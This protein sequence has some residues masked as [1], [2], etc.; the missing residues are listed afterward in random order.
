[1]EKLQ[2]MLLLSV[3][4]AAAVTAGLAIPLSVQRFKGTG[5]WSCGLPYFVH[6]IRLLRPHSVVCVCA[7]VSHRRD[8]IRIVCNCIVRHRWYV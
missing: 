4:I 7:Y 6:A 5:L 2:S 8:K 3:V 1:M